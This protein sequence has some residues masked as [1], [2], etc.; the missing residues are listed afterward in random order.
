MRFYKLGHTQLKRKI[1][2]TRSGDVHNKVGRSEETQKEMWARMIVQLAK[3]LT[4]IHR[5][6]EFIDHQTNGK[7]ARLNSTHF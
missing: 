4:S 3:Y 7:V 5:G 6:P 2:P 1:F